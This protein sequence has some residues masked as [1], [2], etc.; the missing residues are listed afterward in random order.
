MWFDKRLDAV[1][2]RPLFFVVDIS[3]QDKKSEPI[4]RPLRSFGSAF[5]YS[6]YLVLGFLVG[7]VCIKGCNLHF[8][9]DGRGMSIFLII[10]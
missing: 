7:K 4:Q 9:P 3:N 8:I 2:V 6:Q 10:I 5:S 1:C